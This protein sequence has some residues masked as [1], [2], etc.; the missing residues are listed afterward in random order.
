MTCRREDTQSELHLLLNEICINHSKYI[1]TRGRLGINHAFRQWKQDWYRGPFKERLWAQYGGNKVAYFDSFR[2]DAEIALAHS[3]RLLADGMKAFSAWE[4][5]LTRQMRLQPYRLAGQAALECLTALSMS[6]GGGPHVDPGFVFVSIDFEGG[7]DQYGI[8]EFGVTKLDTRRL[9]A[10]SADF[11][12][13]DD[14]A[15]SYNFAFKCNQGRQFRW[16]HTLRMDSSRLQETIMDA[17]DIR[18][19]GVKR[20]RGGCARK[21]V[22]L[23]H[24]ISYDLNTLDQLGLPIESIPAISGVVDTLSLSVEVLGRGCGSRSL[25]RLLDELDIPFQQQTLHCAGNDSH[26]TLR[27]LLALLH[28][29]SCKSSKSSSYSQQTYLDCLNDFVRQPVPDLPCR[30]KAPEHETE[31]N[32]DGMSLMLE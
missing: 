14:L 19:E 28:M 15:E 31:D 21:I 3:E 16:G 6:D 23:G 17:L 27:A 29:R 11:E 12:A 7:V 13:H 10:D 24:S 20:G 8:K 9:I 30:I 22:L 2:P 18:E 4:A 25:G 26:Y 1:A 32:L 5:S